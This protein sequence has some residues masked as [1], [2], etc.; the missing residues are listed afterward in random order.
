MLA[1]S[2]AGTLA[3][4]HTHAIAAAENVEP[5][6][7]VIVSDT[8]LGR[9][10]NE[11]AEKNWRKAISEI[12]DLPS[13]F[14]LHLGD[15][16]DSGRESQY[17]IYAETRKLLNKPIHE[18]PGNHDASDLFLQYVTKEPDR[19]VDFGKVRFVMFSNARRDSHDGFIT[20]QQNRWL[21]EQCDD[22]QRRD[23]KIVICCHVPVH[24]NQNPDR[25]WYVK[26]LAGQT[27]FYETQQRH[28]DR[29]LA[30]LHGHFHN[31]IRGWRDHG[32]TVEVLCP[33]VCYNQNRNL[34]ERIAQG[35][36]TGFFVDE[37]RPGYAI[38]ELGN[39][40]LTLRYK[41]LGSEQHGQYT[42]LWT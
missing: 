3:L 1:C 30:C 9:N 39:G 40:K 17:P 26:P 29:L 2:A 12:N 42:A 5:L 33:S 35:T 14:I 15:V 6:S 34:T 41:P 13:Q 22:A 18:I 38:A 37:L 11:S 10:D 28:A 27:A 8:H 7:F 25:G 16:V 20:D 31:G 19:S 4:C 24:T 23:L 36:A 21:A 32:Q